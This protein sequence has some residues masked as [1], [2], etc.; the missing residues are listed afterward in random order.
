MER[1]LQGRPR[2]T[3][4]VAS[5]AITA[6]H[7]ELCRVAFDGEDWVHHY[8]RGVVVERSPN[9]FT[10]AMRD[11]STWD[12]FLYQYAPQPGDVVVDL[13]AGVGGEVRE[14][15]R[16][17][18]PNGRVVSVEAHPAVFRC[19][20]KTVRLNRLC[21]VQTVHCAVSDRTGVVGIEDAAGHVGNAVTSAETG[22]KV[23][24]LPLRQIM[25]LAD[26]DH[27][28]FLKVNIEGFEWPVL[29][30][31]SDL[32]R[33]VRHVAV[34]CHDF[35]ADRTGND[36]QR[37]FENVSDLIVE[38]GFHLTTRPND[39]RSWVRNYVYGSRVPARQRP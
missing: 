23:R 14:L 9:G 28:D 13:G 26:I 31:S 30:E 32:L 8:P 25:A 1:M 34:A 29:R 21:N 39:E 2:L 37:T 22:L 15:S 16:L 38:A 27:I 20:E 5:A 36:W 7:R 18:G 11:A 10:A 4:A 17:V 35:N 19:L 3:G 6:K 24:A 33:H 12:V